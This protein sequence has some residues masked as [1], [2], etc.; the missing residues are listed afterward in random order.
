LTSA[1][2]PVVKIIAESLSQHDEKYVLPTPL[3]GIRVG[4]RKE[5]NINRY[6]IS[7]SN[8]YNQ[9]VSFFKQCSCSFMS[10]EIAGGLELYKLKLQ[11]NRIVRLNS[12]ESRFHFKKILKRTK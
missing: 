10:L 3:S 7:S 1:R 9:L 5:H 12:N 6:L 11:Y 4:K 2:R 8:D